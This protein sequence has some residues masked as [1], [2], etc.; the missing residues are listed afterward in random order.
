MTENTSTPD[1]TQPQ[2]RSGFYD[3]QYM[4]GELDDLT[5]TRTIDLLDEINSLRVFV[6]RLMNECQKELDA[7]TLVKISQ[8]IARIEQVLSNLI[9]TQKYLSGGETVREFVLQLF[10]A[11]DETHLLLKDD[12]P[13]GN[14]P[15]HGSE[16]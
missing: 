4:K 5:M 16:V 15:Q 11:R 6:R 3:E 12:L 8:T 9:R 1:S 13:P 2:K 7:E 14:N 10:K